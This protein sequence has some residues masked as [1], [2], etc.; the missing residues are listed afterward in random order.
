MVQQGAFTIHADKTDL[1]GKKTGDHPRL[2]GFRVKRE[3]KVTLR[4]DLR[5]LGITRSGLFPDL[6]SLA[7]D[8][9]RKPWIGTRTTK[10][11]P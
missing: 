8:L 9:K 2:V 7:R 11:S 3:A 10:P 6:E 4:E 1:A 5:L